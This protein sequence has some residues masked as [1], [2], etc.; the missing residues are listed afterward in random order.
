LVVEVGKLNS[1][2]LYIIC[3]HSGD[4][5]EQLRFY[6]GEPQARSAVLAN[7]DPEGTELEARLK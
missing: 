3:L 6:N 7:Y 1:G 5:S 2:V 4:M